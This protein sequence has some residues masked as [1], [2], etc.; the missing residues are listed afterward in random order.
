MR[1][2]SGDLRC[3]KWG[4]REVLRRIYGAVRDRNWRTVPA[5]VSVLNCEAADRSFHVLFESEHREREIDFVWRGE[6]TGD[7]KGTI[8]FTFEGEARSTFLRNRIGFC[9]L[10]PVELAGAT[11]RV[12]YA[13][14]SEYATTF[15]EL[16]AAEQPITAIHDLGAVAHEIAPGLWAEVAFSGDLFEMEDQ[17]NWIDASY[18]TYCTPLRLPFPL[19]ITA[20]TCITQS[21]ELRLRGDRPIASVAPAL[22]D[23]LEQTVLLSRTELRFPLPPIGLGLSSFRLS[24]G[25]IERLVKLKPAHLRVDLKPAESA[26]DETL[27]RAVNE[28]GRLNAPLEIALF[29]SDKAEAE[30]QSLVNLLDQRRPRVA[31]WLIFDTNAKASTEWSLRLARQS[32]SPY[33]AP[34]GG[35]A[36][37]DFYQLNQFRPPTALMDFVAFSMNP[38][39]HAFDDESLLETLT[40]IPYPIRSA[41]RYFNGLPVVISPLTLKPRF[42]PVATAAEDASPPDQL[43]PHV[44]VRQ[45]SLFGAAWT[46]GAVKRLLESDVESITCYEAA[47]WCGVMET[48]NGSPLP[49]KFPSLPGAVFPLYHVL[50]DVAAFA[51]GD[52]IG[53]QS[54]D[55]LRVE[56][57]LL[58]RG[59]RRSLLLANLTPEA[60]TAMMV[61]LDQASRLRRLRQ[62]NA[63]SAMCDPTTFRSQFDSVRIS[64]GRIEL[65]PFEIVRLDW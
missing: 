57:M 7:Q 34:I 48:E 10:H 58:D 9:V 33:G 26:V 20:G 3:I 30:L 51:G 63:E 65:S 52:L 24:T 18:K 38:Q 37:A 31:R 49:Q 50:A 43:P 2:E 32:L 28:A 16:V 40:A 42:N 61:G 41:K 54:G 8:R 5:K 46:L 45:V 25:E 59:E 39:T 35:G 13:N 27:H 23:S 53:V 36:N 64:T 55:A 6:I 1:F 56:A 17:R 21:V 15:P 62:Q 12:R 47:G 19:E 44:D 29:L 11:C 4:E 60:Q 14:G 22:T